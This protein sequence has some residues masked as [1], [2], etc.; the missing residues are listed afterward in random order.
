MVGGRR[1][2]ALVGLAV[3]GFA[4]AAL[5]LL[6]SQP[7]VPAIADR[8]TIHGACLACK[9]EGRVDYKRGELAPHPCPACREAAVYPLFYCPHCKKRFV[10]RI[11]RIDPA[12]PPR[13]PLVVSCPRCGAA[14]IAPFIPGGMVEEPL[15]DLPWPPWPQ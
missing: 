7:G 10:P 15:G 13:M 2:L 1:N 12:Q 14:D 11:W 9:H 4:G 3:A 8:F 5:F 6:R